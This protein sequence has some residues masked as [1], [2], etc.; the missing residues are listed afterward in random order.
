VKKRCEF[1]FVSNADEVLKAALGIDAVKPKG[2]KEPT[3]KKAEPKK[4][5]A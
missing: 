2:K 1:K 3:E 4:A 5:K